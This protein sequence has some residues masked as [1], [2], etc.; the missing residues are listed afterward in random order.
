MKHSINSLCAF[1]V[2]TISSAYSVT[3]T[4]LNY[5]G[6]LTTAGGMT[7]PDG[8]YSVVF[9]IYNAAIGGTSKWTETQSVT[10]SG[11][12]FAVLLGTVTPVTDTVFS[13]TKR[14]LGV[15]VGADPELS[16]RTS[17]V[18]VPFAYRV[19]TIDGS[20]GGSISGNINLDSSAATTGNIVKGG[21][22]FLH[23]F[24]TNNVFVGLNTGNLTMTGT[25]NVGTGP[26]ALS[27]NTTGYFN[28]ANGSNALNLN[29]TGHGNTASGEFALRS[30]TIG[31]NNVAIGTSALAQN[32][33]GNYN[34]A[35]GL[36]ALQN[37][38]TG[39]GNTATGEYALRSNVSG[40]YNTATGLG[41]MENNI[42][43]DSNTAIGE[44][45]LNSNTTGRSNTAS[46]LGAL[47][48]DTSGSYN[49]ASGTKVLY[50]NTSGSANTASG[51]RALYF[52]TVGGGNTA[53]GQSALYRNSTGNSNTAYGG[54]AL[55]NNTTGYSNAACGSNALLTN[56][57]GRQNTAVGYSA[58]VASDALFNATAI[59]YNANVNASN[60][61]RL[62]NSSV[63]VIE[64]QVAYTFTSDKNQKE[65]FQPVDGGEVLR[66]IR[67]LS[68]T[69]WNYKGN[70]P[71]R[72]RHYGP[73]AQE[74][75][76][77]FGHDCVGLS[78]DSVS[79]NSGDMAGVMMIAI[80]TLEREKEQMKAEN[81]ALKARLSKLEEALAEL[82]S[83]GTGGT[84]NL[85]QK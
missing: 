48:S 8:S 1:L 7:V 23:N 19:S 35:T 72:F 49:S 16:P 12:L 46:G 75:Y 52:N 14:Y 42:S 10:T 80:Q 70:D 61:I 57:T 38:T 15:R 73:V 74:F 77:A 9:T 84:M 41:A 6:R 17:L 69:S 32:T 67:G 55:E 21:T 85:V 27:S 11:G 37:N 78:G 24:G 25:D 59:G 28:T 36:G 81:A 50:S 45:A 40:T 43:G 18:T 31:N 44:L 47:Y 34:S 13:S 22:L 66:K 65:N 60:K 79:I 54:S 68:L 30:N 4:S 63:T 82:V 5:Q 3:P 71:T 62:G 2:L 29:T 26:N 58:D 64:G 83:V 33:S 76:A 53:S 39:D 51:Y 20:S 56:A